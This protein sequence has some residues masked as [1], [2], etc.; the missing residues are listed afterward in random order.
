MLTNWILNHITGQG[1]E[2]R[3]SVP[4]TEVLP[5]DEPVTK[6]ANYN[7]VKLSVQYNLC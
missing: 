4:E 2:P 5:L 6:S 1:F 3:L 7:L